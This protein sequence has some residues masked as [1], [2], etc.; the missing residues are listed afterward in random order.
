MTTFREMRD[1]YA[2]AL[3]QTPQLAREE[4]VAW[5]ERRQQAALWEKAETFA[6]L[7]E[8]VARFCEGELVETP[9]HGGP[10]CPETVPVAAQL[11]HANR[12]GF[13][14][15]SSQPGYDH[16][17]SQQ[18]AAVEGWAMP[19]TAEQLEAL[20]GGTRLQLQVSERRAW[21]ADY[22]R[23]FLVSRYVHP[24]GEV[25]E[26]THFGFVPGS[27]T[28]FIDLGRSDLTDGALFVTVHDPEWGDHSL[29][30][31]R[32]AT[33]NWDH[34]HPPTAEQ[35]R[36]VQ[37]PVGTVLETRDGDDVYRIERLPDG[38]AIQYR[39]GEGEYGLA[40]TSS[41]I[42]WRAAWTA[43]GPPAGTGPLVPMPAGAPPL[44]SLPEEAP[45]DLDHPGAAGGRIDMPPAAQPYR[46]R[47]S[48]IPAPARQPPSPTI[49]G[50]A[51]STSIE[52]VKTLI[53]SAI[54]DVG[55]AQSSIHHAITEME[56]ARAGFL[57]AAEGSSQQDAEAAAAT[58]TAVIDNLREALGQSTAAVE[59]TEQVGARL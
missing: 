9:D 8:L 28:D 34:P 58:L 22:S 5:R 46:P 13:V 51:M 2:A 23:A 12:C 43:W 53:A 37:P 31:D 55:G 15:T 24:D 44:P 6:D 32:L 47:P 56:R 49:T 1:T 45:L 36:P 18:R 57:A 35:K 30:W 26:E 40:H 20:V 7:G 50:D 14:T 59:M 3:L 52:Q 38:W 19:E 54:A 17:G 48:T 27:R 21:R 42:S 11:A 4:L 39:D 16:D 29:L 41:R 33:P 25:L 10:R